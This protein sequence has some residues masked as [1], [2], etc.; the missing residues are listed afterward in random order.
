MQQLFAVAI[1]ELVII[2]D[3]RIRSDSDSVVEEEADRQVV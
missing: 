1:R 2:I 3:L